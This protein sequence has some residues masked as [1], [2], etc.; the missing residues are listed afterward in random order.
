[1]IKNYYADKRARYFPPV[2]I[3]FFTSAIAFLII[4]LSF[5]D[6]L[7]GASEKLSDSLENN[8]KDSAGLISFKINGEKVDTSNFF[9]STNIPNLTYEN[10]DS[11]YK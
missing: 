8:K 6:S 10:F 1:M 2:R 4:S 5:Q 3:Y 9:S 7:E 11:L